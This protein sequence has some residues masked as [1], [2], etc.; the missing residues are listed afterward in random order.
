MHTCTIDTY[1]SQEERTALHWASWRGH[2]TTVLVL[3]EAKANINA[4]DDVSAVYR[5]DEIRTCT[6]LC[7][8]IICTDCRSVGLTILSKIIMSSGPYARVQKGELYSDYVLQMRKKC[9][10]H[11]ASANA[12]CAV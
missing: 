11:A 9:M 6:S 1:T 7:G 8:K 5:S 2:T 10:Q 4:R 12:L 3:L